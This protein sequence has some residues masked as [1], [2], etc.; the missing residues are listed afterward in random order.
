MGVGKRHALRGQTVQVGRGD[1]AAFRVQT[2]HVAVAQIIGQNKNHV[3]F[4]FYCLCPCGA[5]EQYQ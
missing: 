5:S 4:W 1:F 2:M 3:G